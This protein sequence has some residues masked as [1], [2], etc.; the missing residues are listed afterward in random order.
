MKKIINVYSAKTNSVIFAAKDY[1]VAVQ[2]LFGNKWISTKEEI[3]IEN[4]YT[5][6]EKYFGEDVCDMMIYCWDIDNFNEFWEC[7]FWMEEVEYFD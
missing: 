7:D 3:V 4:E 2:I 5:T 1:R 6:L